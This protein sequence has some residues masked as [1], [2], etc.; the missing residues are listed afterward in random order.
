MSYHQHRNAHTPIATPMMTIGSTHLP[1]RS[2]RAARSR[3][4]SSGSRTNAA[5]PSSMTVAPSSMA[6]MCRTRIDV[7]RLAEHVGRPPAERGIVGRGA[8]CLVARIAGVDRHL[9]VDAAR[10]CRHHHDA[11]RQEHALEYAV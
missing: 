4:A 11:V 7:H 8:E 3:R 2:T 9:L 1:T 10:P 5:V 6:V